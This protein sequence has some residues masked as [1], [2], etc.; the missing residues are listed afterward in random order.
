MTDDGSDKGLPK[1]QVQRKRQ[2]SN[3][4]ADDPELNKPAGLA[5]Q[6]RTAQ[7]PQAAI[8]LLIA[9]STSARVG[10][11]TGRK[12]PLVAQV[13]PASSSVLPAVAS[14]VNVAT[15]ARSNSST[16]AQ[17]SSSASESSE[18][19]SEE[20][21]Q[22]SESDHSVAGDLANANEEGRIDATAQEAPPSK[23][24]IQ[25]AQRP[26]TLPAFQFNLAN[27]KKPMTVE[28]LRDFILWCL[29]S[30]GSNP[31][32][33][34]VQNRTHI[35]KLALLHVPRFN[36]HCI[37][38]TLNPA[39]PIS[40]PVELPPNRRA[41]HHVP[42]G[43]HDLDHL[44]SPKPDELVPEAALLADLFPYLMPL[45]ASGPRN[46]VENS[47][48]NLLKIPMT[49]QEKKLAKKNNRHAPL[50]NGTYS[51]QPLLLSLADMKSHHY[52][53]HP[54]LL[55]ETD[56][57]NATSLPDGYV[58]TNVPRG[59]P[60]PS[61]KSRVLLAVDCEMCRAADEH[62]LA[63]VSVVNEAGKV[64][65]DSLVAPSKPI[66]DYVTQYSGITPA[67]LEG[68]TVTI[69]DVQ[70]HIENDLRA[71]RL[72]HPWLIDT[73]I[74]FAQQQLPHNGV[75]NG[76]GL[77]IRKPSLKNLATQ[78]LERSIQNGKSNAEFGNVG[79][80]SV[81]DALAC[82][83]LVK[84]KIAKGPD[85][86]QSDPAHQLLQVL[87]RGDAAKTS[88]WC[89]TVRSCQREGNAADHL[90]ASYS[91]EEVTQSM[92]HAIMGTNAGFIWGRLLDVERHFEGH[93]PNPQQATAPAPPADD[94]AAA[95]AADPSKP[96]LGSVLRQTTRHIKTVWDS[97][98]S[99]G[100]LIVFST[101]GEC[102]EMHKM[103]AK[104]KEAH[105]QKLVTKPMDYPDFRE[106]Y[107]KAIA[108]AKA[109][110]VMFA[111]KE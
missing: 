28:Q 27:V 1:R 100:V 68:V 106:A 88:A 101:R 50:I 41:S 84:L 97:L 55:P 11:G 77:T 58:S 83:D 105:A 95:A 16:A 45:R 6:Q 92:R 35:R 44:I 25:V 104:Q 108:L 48:A 46:R 52:P 78:F 94:A 3:S 14:A 38:S 107:W 69:A 33:V 24:L 74:C 13:N 96:D 72:V 57:H 98:P 22:D 103:S 9:S 89:D 102:E 73:A 23:K 75:E 47:I 53:I 86:G 76:Q 65:L 10:P 42:T 70:R 31:P 111:V 17:Q 109:G 18:P 20:S 39:D 62:I 4:L 63:R 40:V 110:C 80:S 99:G 93:E 7:S 67:M 21:S 91:D 79:H 66:V 8:P 85:F 36:P 81:E 37:V 51:V 54:S 26:P 59:T 64:L 87:R 12:S 43:R 61:D 60:Q 49:E 29:H 82:L 30:E 15:L 71:L 19:S 34:M 2:R 5:K 90:F 32:F 56:A